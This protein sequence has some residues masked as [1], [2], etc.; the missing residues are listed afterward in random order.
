MLGLAPETIALFVGIAGTLASVIGILVSLF[1]Y[2]K[3]QR[4][5]AQADASI[6]DTFTI[7]Q[8]SLAILSESHQAVTETLALSREAQEALS[9][10]REV[11]FVS[12]ARLEEL[13]ELHAIERSSGNLDDFILRFV[14]R[15]MLKKQRVTV[16][17]LRVA[18]RGTRWTQT[19]LDASLRRLRDRLR[20]EGDP[21]SDSTKVFPPL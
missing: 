15:S 5:S 2:R 11:L 21:R 1:L 14:E 10:T 13:L 20:F 16:G 4:F 12:R 6:K 19:G 17:D 3:A 7:T 8:R 9:D 18:A